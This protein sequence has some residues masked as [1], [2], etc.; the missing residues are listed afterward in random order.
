MEMG[1]PI[2]ILDYGLFSRVK[3]NDHFKEFVNTEFTEEN[4]YL[5]L[6]T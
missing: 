3:V 5:C 2:D 4:P 1:M 6:L